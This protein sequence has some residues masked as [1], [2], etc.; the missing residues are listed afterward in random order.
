MPIEVTRCQWS[1]IMPMEVTRCQWSYIMPM[2]VTRCQWSYI[3]VILFRADPPGSEWFR[4]DRRTVRGAS[5]TAV[6]AF[7]LHLCPVPAGCLLP[8]I[9]VCSVCVILLYLYICVS[10]IYSC[11]PEITS[12]ILQE[13][14]C[15]YKTFYVT[16]HLLTMTLFKG[17][18]STSRL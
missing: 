6:G 17:F 12:T 9:L 1:Y 5:V 13:I 2:E 10:E 4:V 15:H 8:N 14:S 7:L 18:Y 16:V 11:F 3:I